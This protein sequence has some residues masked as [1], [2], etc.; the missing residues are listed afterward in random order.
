LFITFYHKPNI[1]INFIE[2]ET[3]IYGS[4]PT[5]YFHTTG[6]AVFTNDDY[7]TTDS[8]ST[9][10][11]VSNSEPNQ[12]G[13]VISRRESQSSCLDFPKDHGEIENEIDQEK[14]RK[15]ALLESS[16]TGEGFGTTRFKLQRVP[17]WDTDRYFDDSMIPYIREYLS[18][19]FDT[20]WLTRNPSWKKMVNKVKHDDPEETRFKCRI[21]N[22]HYEKFGLPYQ[23]KPG[24]ATEEGVTL[25]LNPEQKNKNYE[26]FREHELGKSGAKGKDCER[27]GR[28]IHSSIIEKLKESEHMQIHSDAEKMN[29]LVESH[30]NYSKYLVT[31][32]ML[33]TVYAEVKLNIPFL[34]HK[35]VLTLLT[36]NGVSMG[37]HHQDNNAAKRMALHISKH[38][39]VALLNHLSSSDAPYWSLIV[40]TTT[41][42]RGNHY[43]ISFI[44]SLEA[45]YSAENGRILQIRPVMYFYKLLE[46]GHDENAVALLNLIENSLKKDAELGFK[47][48]R[49]FK[50]R[51]IGFASDGAS[52]ML[53]KYGGLAKKIEDYVGKKIYTVHCMAHRLQLATGHAWENQKYFKEVEHLAEN[54]FNFYNNKGH[55]RKS[56]LKETAIAMERQYYQYSGIFKIR[57]LASEFSALHKI[58]KSF[59]TLTTDLE[60]ISADDTYD[61]VTKQQA[62]GIFRKLKNKN[63]IAFFFL[64]LDCLNTLNF[65]STMLQ[66]SLGSI[67]GK[68]TSITNIL[69]IFEKRLSGKGAERYGKF[70]LEFYTEA[71]CVTNDGGN[72]RTAKCKTE[73][74]FDKAVQV[75]FRGMQLTE[76][77]KDTVLD[78]ATYLN[79]L[80]EKLNEYFSVTSLAAYDILIPSNL[81][82]DYSGS[83]NYGLIQMRQIADD[84]NMDKGSVIDQWQQLVSAIANTTEFFLFRQSEPVIFWGK[85][86][87]L[88]HL[89]WNNDIKKI[90]QMILVFPIGSADAERGFSILK[91]ARYDRRSS[92]ATESLDAILRIRINGPEIA[93]LNAL[94]YAQLWERT[95]HLMTDSILGE[96]P[97]VD[98]EP[99]E[100]DIADHI[101]ILPDVSNG[102]YQDHKY[103]LNSNIF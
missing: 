64:H 59:E 30:N 37:T 75:N 66:K 17:D 16:A 33:R 46:I 36:A 62:L 48:E 4:N 2:T 13:A 82:L 89:P 71:E 1:V 14:G 87:A 26:M 76:Q 6:G 63:I 57:W 92:L 101:D 52:V 103:L 5:D 97:P 29:M 77:G 31:A 99:E 11:T 28:S 65:L 60:S 50:Q 86:L 32:R 68:N 96:R 9:M 39:H 40:D 102:K 70:E 43:M 93:K 23:S 61:D 18:E 79:L 72:I 27:S 15:R 55:K 85:M 38:M 41:D 51:L 35:S 98:E 7:C 80:I 49:L 54:V 81:P 22:E 53:G 90:I 42:Y 94:K 88:E 84:W 20:N 58:Y 25:R 24:L 67:I 47:M 34:S 12:V 100:F 21:C 3:H 56:H 95:G 10:S 45:D 8:A 74:N 83:L 91:H 44:R 78:R 73:E 19:R 69:Q